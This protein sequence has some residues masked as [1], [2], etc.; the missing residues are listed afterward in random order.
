MKKKLILLFVFMMFLGM[1]SVSADYTCSANKNWYNC[2]GDAC[3]C[4]ISKDSID[5]MYSTFYY[6]K[7]RNKKT[8]EEDIA[9]CMDATRLFYGPVKTLEAD[10]VSY[11][12]NY[13]LT[14]FDYSIQDYTRIASLKERGKSVED[15]KEFIKHVGVYK[16]YFEKENPYNGSTFGSDNMRYY[17]QKAIWWLMA[18]EYGIV[19][20]TTLNYMWSK[21]FKAH[22]SNA[23]N[24]YN[25][26]KDEFEVSA[27]I[28][29]TPGDG[30]Q[31]IATLDVKRRQNY[32]Y[33]LDIACTNCDSKNSDSKAY[34]I[35][36]TTDWDAIRNSRKASNCSDGVKSH[37]YKSETGSYCR[38]EYH[39]YFPNSTNKIT[40][41]TGRYFT[42]NRRSSDDKYVAADIPDFRPVKV[43]K[44]R[45]CKDGDLNKLKQLSDSSFTKCTGDITIEY[46][47][48]K[49]SVTK[50]LERYAKALESSSA[51]NGDTLVQKAT[52]E[53][54]LPSDLY[55]YVAVG[56]G[57]SKSAITDS[58]LKSGGFKNIGVGNLPISNNNSGKVYLQFSYELPKSSCDK[59]TKMATAYKN[60]NLNC[61]NDNLE[62]VYKKYVN[63]KTDGNEKI[64]QSACVKLYGSSKLGQGG[65]DVEN[66]IKARV[67]NRTSKSCIN[68]NKINEDKTKG[69]SCLLVGDDDEEPNY[70]TDKDGK[71]QKCADGED[72]ETCKKRLCPEVP[73]YCTDKN[74]N[75]KQCADGEDLDA[76][77][78]RLCPGVPN[79][80]T[81]KNGN[82]KQCADG[83]D[84]DA[85]KKR[86]CPGGGG[87]K[88][89]TE[90]GKYYDDNNNVITAKE[91]SKIC[92]NESNHEELG[93]SWNPTSK[94]CCPP[95][96]KYSEDTKTCVPDGSGKCRYE[97]NVYYD[98]NGNRIT[99][100]QYDEVCVSCSFF[101]YA[102]SGRS[103][104]PVAGACCPVGQYY[105]EETKKCENKHCSDGQTPCPDGKCPT[106]EGL[107]SG[108][109]G[110][111]PP[112]ANTVVYH[113]I[114]LTNPFIGKAGKNRTTGGNWCENGN[115][116]DCSTNNAVVKKII[117]SKSVYN[118]EHKLYEI[119]LDSKTIN[120]IRKY[121]RKRTYDD[122]DLTCKSDGSACTSKF[123][124][125]VIRSNVQGK[126]ANASKGKFY[127]CDD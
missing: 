56:S 45:E 43:T 12:W 107:C 50:K 7:I 1:G 86:L 127:T 13:R 20:G 115:N 100:E 101:T 89:R 75:K 11:W 94:K 123:L 5:G 70:C 29:T 28:W 65:S 24:F 10:A 105:N 39:V 99:K 40:I 34:V 8:N 54:T 3:S 88:C 53:Y 102:A 59:Y 62:N 25:Q 84:L 108:T 110:I 19:E 114:D 32:D 2:D 31:P 69:Y 64:E 42:L 79:Y 124:N 15:V 80:C 66:C 77:K 85:C 104:N 73:N 103:W 87:G 82:K 93:L 46:K 97:N 9:Y 76:C 61:K 90:N 57:L 51:I 96:Q 68:Q 91:Y 95:D 37:F 92:C 21:G 83:E 55:R 27:Q 71:K 109:P 122:W 72:L 63:G 121:N 17:V 33:S 111:K 49:Y 14:T 117:T 119:T 60:G 81:D 120:T 41:Q 113:T 22:I 52:Y 26:H 126:C 74:G 78:K 16:Y 118:E 58:E 4:E 36:D 18:R 67:N 23:E 30:G 116:F 125:S 98:D 106:K 6:A 47:E 44:I 112:G 35:Q 38:E 48:D